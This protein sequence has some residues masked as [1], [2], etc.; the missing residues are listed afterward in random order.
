MELHV[1]VEMIYRLNENYY[2]RSL[3]LSDLDGAYPSW[4]ENQEVCQYNSHGKFFKT[5]EYFQNYIK[6][7]NANNL[8][9]WAICHNKNGHIGNI[10]LQNISFINRTAELAILLGEKDHW[11]KGVGLIASKVLLRHGFNKL[12]LNRIYCSTAKNNQGMQKISTGLGMKLEG[13]RR[14]HLFLDG[15]Y[16]DMLEYGILHSEFDKT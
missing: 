14:Q 9:V 5:D 8:V 16:L 4:F 3:K 13:E 2:V 10:S 7:L 12:N 11:G 1:E 6:G 15:K